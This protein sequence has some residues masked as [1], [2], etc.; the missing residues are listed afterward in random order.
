M[1]KF[2]RLPKKYVALTV[3]ERYR[4]IDGGFGQLPFLG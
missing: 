4:I 1:T 2:S 3:R